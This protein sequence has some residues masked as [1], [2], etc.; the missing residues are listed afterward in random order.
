ME[1]LWLAQA[2]KL[3]S[4]AQ[5]GIA[6]S[7]DP[8]DIERF[9]EI[10]EI[11]LS[12]MAQLANTSIEQ[13]PQLIQHPNKLYVTPQIEVR[14]AVFR[15]DKILLV[16]EKT[17]RQ[18]SLPGGY[19]D[20]GLSAKQNIEKEIHEE[21]G[22][23]VDAKHLFALRHKAKGDYRPDLRDFYKLYFLCE[24]SQIASTQQSI[25]VGLETMDVDFFSLDSLPPLSLGRVIPRDIEE[26]FSAYKNSTKTTQFD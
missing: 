17:D 22:L 7:Q 9:E 6:F 10:T 21:A 3:F 8:F 16:Q 1:N 23:I 4:I 14:G 18:W 12:M 24:E 11:A 2:K 26:A 19:A 20:V 15:N 25:K 5:S 13:L